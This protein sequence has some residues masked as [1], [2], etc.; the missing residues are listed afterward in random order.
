MAVGVLQ[1]AKTLRPGRFPIQ[2]ERRAVA[3]REHHIDAPAIRC[4]GR[5]RISGGLRNLRCRPCAAERNHHGLP[6]ESLACLAVQAE[7]LALLRVAARKE[8]PIAPYDRRVETTRRRRRLP[9]NP[10]A[11]LG[12]PRCG[13]VRQYRTA[14]AVRSP[15]T[16]PVLSEF[17]ERRGIALLWLS[18]GTR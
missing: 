17:L 11:G 5:S 12:I 3:V 16:G 4:H 14:A 9:G 13:Q 8:D 1:R 7:H 18:S 6:P 10:R 2:G 15:E